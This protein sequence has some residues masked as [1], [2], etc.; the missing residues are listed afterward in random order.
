MMNVFDF[1]PIIRRNEEQIN[2]LFT[3]LLNNSRE[4]GVP[5]DDSAEFAIR[6]I[7]NLQDAIA[8]ERGV[9]FHSDA[10]QGVGKIA[11]DVDALQVDLLSLSAHKIYGPKGI[12]ALYQQCLKHWS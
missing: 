1:Q 11:C 5:A 6:C 10:V 3:N 12:G 7:H 2:I 4:V 9:L 8:R